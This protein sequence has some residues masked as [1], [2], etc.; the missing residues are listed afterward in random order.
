VVGNSM[1]G[2][3]C[4][5]AALAD[6]GAFAR[7][8]DVHSPGA[9]DWRYHVMSN[10]LAL[11][12]VRAG[13]GWFIKRSPKRWVHRN[14]HYYDESLKSLEEAAEYGDP[15]ADRDGVRAFVGYL[16][17]TFAPRELAAFAAELRQRRDRGRGF[18]IPFAFLYSREDP[19]VPPAVGR[20]FHAL[21]PDAPLVWLD[22]TSHFAHVDTPEAVITELRRL[23]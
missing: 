15:L 3:L 23:L 7:L 19:L 4:M 5:R 2:Y 20:F 13:L 10:L 8:I 14:V 17:D 18:P 11:G 12:P 6:P 21:V 16:R 22:E 1:G 9:P